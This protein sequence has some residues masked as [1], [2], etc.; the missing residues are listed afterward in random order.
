L[1]VDPQNSDIIWAVAYNDYND[2]VF[3]SLD[4]GLSWTKVLNVV[5]G[6]TIAVDPKDSSYVLAGAGY[7]DIGTTPGIVNSLD[8][9][10]SWHYT[11]N[12]SIYA[13]AIDPHNSDIVYAAGNATLLKSTD[14]GQHWQAPVSPWP[15]GYV[16]ALVVDPKNSGTLYAGTYRTGVLKSTDAGFSW[17]SVTSNYDPISVGRLVIDPNDTNVLYAA[18]TDVGMFGS[19]HLSKTTDGGDSWKIIS[20][21]DGVLIAALAIDPKIS[22]TI[23]LGTDSGVWKSLDGASTWSANSEFPIVRYGASLCVGGSWYF[24]VSNVRPDSS[25]KLLG[26]SNGESWQISNW[27]TIDSSRAYAERGIFG[28]ETVGSHSLRVS[29]DGVDSNTISFVVSSCKR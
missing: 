15:F 28:P 29:V 26:T 22:E 18:W 5:G 6:W 19:T 11:S 27:R 20:R 14:G 4:G 21:L 17:V 10:D 8:G 13:L 7:G 24:R 9:G 12:F 23:Y 1:V 16:S 25:V 3:K 2:G